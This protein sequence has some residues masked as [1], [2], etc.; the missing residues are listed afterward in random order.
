[1]S[2]EFKLLKYLS[3]QV[4][5]TKQFTDDAKL[6]LQ[7]YLGVVLSKLQYELLRTRYLYSYKFNCYGSATYIRSTVQT[8]LSELVEDSET[9]RRRREESE[10]REEEEEDRRV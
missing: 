6:T 2:S 4:C 5:E 3:L 1:L 8:Y 7:A 10:R 9:D